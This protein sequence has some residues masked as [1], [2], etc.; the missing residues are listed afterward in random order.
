MPSDSSS[1]SDSD[2]D[3]DA[4]E[5][6][7]MSSDKKFIDED[8][9]DEDSGPA[10]T[11][12]TY[13][14]TKNEVPEVEPDIPTVEEVGPDELLEHVGEIMSV[15]GNTVIIKGLA[16]GLAGRASERA[17]DSDTLLVFEDRK[18]LGFVGGPFCSSCL[19]LTCFSLRSMKRLV[20]H[21]SQCIKSNLVRRTNSTSRKCSHHDR[22]STYLTGVTSCFS[23]KSKN[24]K[25]AMPVMSMTKSRRMMSWSSRMTKRKPRSRAKGKESTS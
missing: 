8:L 19:I 12:G 2:S 24:G 17:L 7:Q 22:Y 10:A 5:D 3:S 21:T 13:F 15:V 1:D 14:Q 23:V 4:S 16:A 11:T 18:V 25:A 9:E 6:V 20:P